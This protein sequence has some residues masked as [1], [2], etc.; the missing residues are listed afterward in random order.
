MSLVEE[1][2]HGVWGAVRIIRH[3]PKAFEEFNISADGFWRSFAAI[4]PT[5]VLAWPLFLSAHQLSI[6]SAPSEQKPPT[7]FDLAQDYAYLCLAFLLW[8]LVAVA[9]AKAF[10]VAQ[11]YSR[12]I[13][14]YNWVSVPAIALGLIPHLLHLSGLIGRQSTIVLSLVVF[15][16]LAY[17]SWYVALRG[18]ETTRLIAFAFLLGEY[19]LSFALDAAIR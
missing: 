15:I 8:P 11:T 4:V 1:A 5:A 10:G 12:Y 7:E 19:A 2:L 6:E 9:L 3:D 14:A 17:I 13:I 18:L 16:G